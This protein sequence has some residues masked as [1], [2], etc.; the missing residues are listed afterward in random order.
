[1]SSNFPLKRFPAEKVFL[2]MKQFSP[3]T[4]RILLFSFFILLASFSSLKAQSGLF[5]EQ[6]V[7]SE[8]LSIKV[9]EGKDKTVTATSDGAHKES[10]GAEA[11]KEALSRSSE[12]FP[13]A[14]MMG[15]LKATGEPLLNQAD[16]IDP[17]R[18]AGI[19]PGFQDI[20]EGLE[21]RTLLEQQVSSS[22]DIR[23]DLEIKLGQ[24]NSTILIVSDH[25]KARVME[26]RQDPA[27]KDTFQVVDDSSENP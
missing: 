23:K 17:G 18:V 7:L 26:L 24:K 13:E 5:F 19:Q 3:M 20:L 25:K 15:T 1:M 2:L 21:Q 8:N 11:A 27:G 6:E 12:V 16:A 4:F 14:G 10:T 9:D 22:E